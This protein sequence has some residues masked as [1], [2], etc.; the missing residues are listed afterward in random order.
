MTVF[1]V[2]VANRSNIKS[3]SP[4]TIY[5]ALLQQHNRH[6]SLVMHSSVN[7]FSDSLLPPHPSFYHECIE[8]DVVQQ[9]NTFPIACHQPPPAAGCGRTAF[10]GLSSIEMISLKLHFKSVCQGVQHATVNLG[11]RWICSEQT[12]HG[13]ALNKHHETVAQTFSP[14]YHTF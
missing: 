13:C 3:Q 8:N 5:I 6:D 14:Y 11:N 7:Q 10:L 1:I 2:S 4:H 9:L 12:K